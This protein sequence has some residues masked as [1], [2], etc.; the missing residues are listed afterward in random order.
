MDIA[1]SYL[2]TEAKVCVRYVCAFPGSFDENAGRNIL[3]SCGVKGQECLV[4]LESRSLIEYYW[5][6]TEF[7]YRVHRLIREYFRLHIFDPLTLSDFD[8]NFQE[9]YLTAFLE[10]YTQTGAA[11]ADYIEHKFAVDFSN[12]EHLFQILL[13][14]SISLI[15][16][17]EASV[18]AFGYINGRIPFQE[19]TNLRKQLF[20]ALNNYKQYLWTT[21]GKDRYNSLYADL[22]GHLYE[23]ECKLQ[24]NY[25]GCRCTEICKTAFDMWFT[26]GLRSS[27]LSLQC[28]NCPV[29]LTWGN[30]VIFFQSIGKNLVI[31]IIIITISAFKMTA[32]FYV[33]L[34]PFV[35]R[36]GRFFIYICLFL[37]T[38]LFWYSLLLL[39][40][41]LLWFLILIFINTF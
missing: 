40:E 24:H 15:Y 22:L 29:M 16:E 28:F 35:S 26:Y 4:T 36:I 14:V 20:S 39:F 32:C 7:R 5:L 34:K 23:S 37:L 17:R 3:N 30:L 8:P 21:L 10:L 11:D 27:D 6:G 25:S 2:P 31:I 18:L 41:G 13:N 33:L 19:H 38:I 1:Y 12:L 9:H